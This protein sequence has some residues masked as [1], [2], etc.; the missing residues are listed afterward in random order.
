LCQANIAEIVFDQEYLKG[1][2]PT[3]DVASHGILTSAADLDA[4]F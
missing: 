2:A 4:N 3:A 1:H